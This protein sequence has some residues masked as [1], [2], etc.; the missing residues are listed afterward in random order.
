MQ[1]SKF[2]DYA[3]RILIHLAASPDRLMTTSEISKLHGAKY[4]HL[5][6]V[7]TWLVHEGYAIATRGRGGGLKL[8][9]DADQI[10]LGEVLKDLEKD[11]SMVECM[12]AE[13]GSCRL[14]GA[15]G[16]EAALN[17]AQ[18]SFY[19]TLRKFTLA[20]LTRLKPGMAALLKTIHKELN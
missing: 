7:T 13:G 4:N 20:D 8:A 9:L 14:H 11:R 19:S 16:L 2:S 15:C 12:R 5:T 3:L 10:N 17:E 1:L 6:K 18:E